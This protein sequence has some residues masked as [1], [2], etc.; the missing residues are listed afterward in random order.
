MKKSYLYIGVLVF[1]FTPA[2]NAATCG[3][4]SHWIDTCPA[5]IDVIPSSLIEF[6][7]DLNFDGIAEFDV[8]F[9]GGP[10]TLERSDPRDDSIN[11][12]GTRPLDGHD[13]VIDTEIVSM[14]LTG[15]GASTGWTLR[16]GEDSGVSS[17]HGFGGSYQTLGA[18]AEQPCDSILAVSFFDVFFE[19]DDTPFGTLHNDTALRIGAT[20]DQVV[21]PVGTDYFIHWLVGPHVLELFDANDIHVANLV[22]LTTG[23]GGHHLITPVPAAAWLFG[24]ALIGLIGF[25][26]RKARIAA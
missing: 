18:I 13:D 3:P 26:K 6:G 14:S 12:P 5:G 21:P 4:G 23:G 1:V 24:T 19:I 15:Q 16:V 22:D 25:G 9:T 8:L 17:S 20:I 10:V 2:V 7:V 11:Y